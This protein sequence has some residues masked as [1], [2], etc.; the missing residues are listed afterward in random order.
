MTK[1]ENSYQDLIETIEK[2]TVLELSEFVKAIEEKFGVSGT[3]MAPAPSA[4]VS[5]GAGEA[6]AVE[7]KS[8][9]NVVLK[10]TGSSKIQVIK[11]VK[12]IT[13]KGLQEAKEITDKTPAVIKEGVK[14]EEAQ[15]LKKKLEDAGATVALE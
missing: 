9:F 2:M 10:D 11:A 5:G 12:E 14:K 1:K 13:G 15:E 7:E 8:T 6:A 3:M 4:A